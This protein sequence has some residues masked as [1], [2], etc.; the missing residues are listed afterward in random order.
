M[1]GPWAGVIDGVAEAIFNRAI[2]IANH[3][4]PPGASPV[5]PAGDAYP[6]G[7]S[8]LPSRDEDDIITAPDPGAGR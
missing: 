1:L 4:V 2:Y 5:A 3:R 8:P 6:N 7:R